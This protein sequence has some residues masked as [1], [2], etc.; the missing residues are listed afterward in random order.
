MNKNIIITVLFLLIIIGMNNINADEM[1]LMNVIPDSN[2]VYLGEEFGITIQNTYELPIAV[3][4][5]IDGCEYTGP[6]III[7][8]K[9][10]SCNE[11]VKVFHGVNLGKVIDSNNF[12]FTCYRPGS[13]IF[14]FTAENRDGGSKVDYEDINIEVK[15]KEQDVNEVVTTSNHSGGR[16]LL[17]E[18]K[19]KYGNISNIILRKFAEFRSNNIDYRIIDWGNQVYFLGKKE[20]KIYEYDGKIYT[21]YNSKILF[22]IN[23]EV[24]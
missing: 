7:K 19:D 24:V 20:E 10:N 5:I 18:M 6:P 23:K 1:D 21:Q 14:K 17:Q 11:K 22:S 16:N 2:V 3:E 9:Y 4:V 13:Q 12:K 8:E 15:K